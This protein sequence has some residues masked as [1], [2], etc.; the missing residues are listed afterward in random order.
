MK[1]FCHSFWWPAWPTVKISCT[2][3]LWHDTCN[4]A[5]NVTVITLIESTYFVIS[6]KQKLTFAFTF[7]F[8]LWAYI[9]MTWCLFTNRCCKKDLLIRVITRLMKTS[10]YCS[11]SIP[12]GFCYFQNLP[13]CPFT[14]SSDIKWSGMSVVSLMSRQSHWTSNHGLHFKFFI[15][16]SN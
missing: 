7:F 12:S 8:G 6:T 15:N 4:T 1:W 14:I 2:S 13:S 5:Y 16:H 11:F 10:L 9:R 3:F